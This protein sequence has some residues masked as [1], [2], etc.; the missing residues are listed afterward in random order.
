MGF[1]KYKEKIDSM[2]KNYDYVKNCNVYT[3]V[4]KEELKI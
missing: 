2:T 4:E 3:D 1:K